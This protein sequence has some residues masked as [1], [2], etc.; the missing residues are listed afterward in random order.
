MAVVFVRRSRDGRALD[1]GAE[2]NRGSTWSRW[3]SACPAFG[4][5]GPQDP[6]RQGRPCGLARRPVEGFDGPAA[7]S[8]TAVL[9]GARTAEPEGLG[10]WCV[11]RDRAA[12]A[13]EPRSLRAPISS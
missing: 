8:E 10:H 11:L 13:A 3:R 2:R 7:S 4:R 6:K 12:A 5:H 1:R 9:Q